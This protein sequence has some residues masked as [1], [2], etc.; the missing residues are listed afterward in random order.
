MCRMCDML[1]GGT[2]EGEA[3]YLNPKNYSNRMYKLRE[4]GQRPT[5]QLGNSPNRGAET[6]PAV[7][8]PQAIEAKANGDL[9]SY[10]KI[11]GEINRRTALRP[12]SQVVPMFEI[13]K[14]LDFGMP[15]AAMM[16][17]CRKNTRAVEETNLSEYS[18]MGLGTG[19][20][21]WERWPERY[22]G[23]VEF[24][25]TKQAKEWVEYWDKKGM[26]H[27][28]M[29]EGGDFIG[30]LCN[31]DYPDCL[32]IRNRVDYGLW[33][34]LVKSEYVCFV[35]WEKCNGCGDCLGRCSFNA[36]KFETTMEKAHIDQ[37]NCFGCGLC[38]TACP[39]DAISY[40]DR[41]KVPGL[42]NVW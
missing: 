7:G 19:M 11:I 27:S 17:I 33:S 4:P 36:L 13:M 37:F 24:L 39:R 23:G 5:E 42:A 9:D 3:W 21:K 31:C 6:T 1:G 22:R 2:N 34:Q 38:E 10:N 30:G 14:V 29:Q 28:L 35:D 32:L 25:S 20:L 8:L 15:V 18:G 16:C 26:M 12:G 40:L 41:K